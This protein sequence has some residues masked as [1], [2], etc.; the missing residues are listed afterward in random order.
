LAVRRLITGSNLVCCIT[1]NS[2]GLAPS[3][4]G[5]RSW[6]LTESFRQPRAIAHETAGRGEFADLM[7]R[8]GYFGFVEPTDSGSAG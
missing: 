7:N 4:Y 2:A 1:R 8:L 3:E 5:S 6:G